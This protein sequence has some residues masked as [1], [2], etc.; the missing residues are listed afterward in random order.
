MTPLFENC[1]GSK[2]KTF[3]ANYVS[4]A[5]EQI[6]GELISLKIGLIIVEDTP[7]YPDLIIVE[8][9]RLTTIPQHHYIYAR[10]RRI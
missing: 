1:F 5:F 3:S 9:N 6:V 7:G 8:G 2:L 10:K 4:I